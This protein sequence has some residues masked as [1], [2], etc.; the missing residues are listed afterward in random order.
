MFLGTD[1]KVYI[2]DKSENNKAQV[3]G[4]PA[5]GVEYD[6]NSNTYRAMDVRSN[7]FCAGGATLGDG[8]YFVTGG[9]KAVKQGGATAQQGAA[10]YKDYNG[11]KAI[12]FLTPCDDE[13][14]NWVDKASNQ[15]VVERWYPTVEPLKDGHVIVIGGMRD[16]GFVPS[17]NSNEASYEFYPPKNNGLQRY[18]PLIDR[19]VPL[20][21]YPITFLM[22]SGELFIQSGRQAIL[23]N[24]Q[25]QSENRL[26]NI[27]HAPRVYPASAGTVL[28]PLRPKNNYL[29]TVL[30]CGG[31]S[32]G[33]A[34]NWGN[35]GG[36]SVMVTERPASNKC[37]QISP[38]AGATWTTV[39][40]LPQAR[41][42]GQF[43]I[44]PDG[45][46]WFGNGVQTGVA[47][48]ST[49]PNNAGQPVGQSFGDN[50]SYQVSARAP[51]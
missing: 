20:N 22:S 45:K 42:M 36:P 31:M 34:A 41:S 30:F 51:L 5:W 11:G 33:K 39:D 21:L 4:H 1:S 7:T 25:K 46:L 14:C 9:N 32:L 28:L 12:R 38:L 2:L 16:G 29:E 27:P 24:Y 18:L 44:M 26:P 40:D 19:T 48:Y 3:N 6:I 8:R 50:P 43:I 10:P 49:D 13:S 47:G 17:H 15:L 37:D 23:W 35:E